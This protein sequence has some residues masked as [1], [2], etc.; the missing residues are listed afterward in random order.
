MKKSVEVVAAFLVVL[1]P[2]LARGHTYAELED[3]VIEHELENGM[4]FLIFERHDAPLVSMVITVKAGAVN[5]V[6]NKT[7]VAHFLEHLA[8]KGTK[9]MGTTNYKKEEKALQQLD[10]AFFAYRAAQIEGA[11]QGPSLRQGHNRALF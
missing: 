3:R 9:T 4:R 11:L 1:T 2:L 5:E 10:D 6:T 8:F 7:G